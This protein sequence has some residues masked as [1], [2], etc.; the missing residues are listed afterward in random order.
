MWK[1]DHIRRVNAMMN[2]PTPEII[3]PNPLKEDQGFL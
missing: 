3:T 2:L 1:E